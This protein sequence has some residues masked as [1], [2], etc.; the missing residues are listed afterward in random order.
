MENDDVSLISDDDEEQNFAADNIQEDDVILNV[1]NENLVMNGAAVQYHDHISDISSSEDDVIIDS[2][3]EFKEDK[4]YKLARNHNVVA[5]LPALFK[6]I[7]T[8][9]NVM[10]GETDQ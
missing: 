8:Y 1:E 3:D 5:K 10:K 6:R 2:D 7:H 4:D 9:S